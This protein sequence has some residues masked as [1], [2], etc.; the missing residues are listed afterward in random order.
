MRPSHL[1]RTVIPGCSAAMLLAALASWAAAAD[2]ANL[3]IG[4]AG[5]MGYGSIMA[6]SHDTAGGV[7]IVGKPLI[8]SG[9]QALLQA[10]PGANLEIQAGVGVGGGHVLASSLRNS[11]GYS[12]FGSGPYVAQANFTY[13]FDGDGDGVRAVFLRGGLFDYDYAQ[14]NQNLGLYLLR[15]PVYPGYIISGFE[16][17]HV[18]PVAN[19]LGLQFHR[20]SG[21]FR[22]DVLLQVETEFYPFYDVSPAYLAAFQGEAFRIGGGVNFHHLIPVDP[23]LTTDTTRFRYTDNSHPA[24]PDT[25]Q[26]SAK[27]IKLM[28]NGMVDMKAVF[29]GME[30]LGPEDLKVYG[31][32]GVI[33]LGGLFRDDIHFGSAPKYRKNS[34]RAYEDLYGP[35]S[36]R[37]PKMIGL[38][39]P[40]FKLLD[41]LAVEV[42]HYGAP[43]KD[44]ITKLTSHTSS[45][46]K[47]VAPQDPDSAISGDD[48]RWSVYAARVIRNHIKVS[49]QVASDHYRPGLFVGY[50]DNA[51]PSTEAVLY[52]PEDWYLMTKVAYFF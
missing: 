22:Q 23:D 50:G 31:E 30:S 11:G 8:S 15:G 46:E 1:P 25:I 13:R 21:G 5:W 37:M 17:K 35:I 2:G 10:R 39:L 14:E 36:Q 42:E 12:P 27:G 49:L 33:G 38:N 20:R 47:S 4:G 43:F 24:A 3:R 16:T 26:L 29:G 52:R 28:V 40:T 6:S 41:R 51:P 44:D 19:T 18:L 7:D 9:A 48:I 34:K 32:V 45:N